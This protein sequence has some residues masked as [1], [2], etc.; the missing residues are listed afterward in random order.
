MSKTVTNRSI[1]FF[2]TLTI[3]GSIAV[4][5]NAQGWNPVIWDG[6][7]QLK[8]IRYDPFS[9][10]IQI[11][12]ERNKVRESVTDP[13]RG[14]IDPGSYCYVNEYQTDQY[15]S[16]WHVR[17]YR[18]TSYGVPHGNL[19]RTRVSSVGGIDHKENENVVYGAVTHK[20]TENVAFSPAT[21]RAPTTTP[22]TSTSTTVRK[23]I[24]KSQRNL[25]RQPAQRSASQ[26]YN[27][28]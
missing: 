5:A 26:A 14:Y 23:P 12:T 8:G 19:S 20:E 16:R 1:V 9:G 4:Q 27:P 18:W 22:Q 3:F 15:G 28:F 25:T 17:G 24:R 6:G 21:T 7:Q 13:N 2:A 10:R 11:E